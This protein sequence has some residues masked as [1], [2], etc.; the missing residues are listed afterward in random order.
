[1]KT[2][3]NLDIKEL[4]VKTIGELAVEKYSN[5]KTLSIKLNEEQY[6]RLKVLAFICDTAMSEIVKSFL[7]QFIEQYRKENVIEV[8]LSSSDEGVL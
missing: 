7:E 4:H 2:I 5:K 1:M 3:T 8:S 6:K